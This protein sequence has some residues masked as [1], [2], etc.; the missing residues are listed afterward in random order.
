MR[1]KRELHVILNS[2]YASDVEDILQ[3]KPVSSSMFYNVDINF[4]DKRVINPYSVSIKTQTHNKFAKA[5]LEAN[6]K[7]NYQ[8]DD[9]GLELRFFAG[10]FLSKAD[11]LSD[12]YSYKLSGTS[13]SNDYQFENTFLGRFE[14]AQ[15]RSQQDFLFHQFVKNQGGFSTYAPF[16]QSNNWMVSLNVT[17]TIPKLPLKW[18]VSVAT[19]DGAGKKQWVVSPEETIKTKT[20]AW[21]TGIELP[22]KQFASIYFPIL[23]S[24]DL[25]EINKQFTGNYFQRIRFVINFNELNIFKL[26]AKLTD[27]MGK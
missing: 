26:R 13:G 15:N 21:E 19:Y 1:S 6:Y 11:N 16:I 2:N 3:E 7:I 14:D 18:Y 5:Q 17:T 20:I 22:L 25:N 24:N 12:V 23:V 27:Q 4:A 9:K 8:S 10:T